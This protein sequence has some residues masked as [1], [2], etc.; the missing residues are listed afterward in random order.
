M[1]HV[2]SEKDFLTRRDWDIQSGTRFCKV[3]KSIGTEGIW[4]LNSQSTVS[5]QCFLDILGSQM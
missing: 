1:L 4:H 2:T 3:P 5:D